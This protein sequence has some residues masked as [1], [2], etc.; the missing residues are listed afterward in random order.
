M[1]LKRIKTEGLKKEDP[2]IIPE[3]QRRDFLKIGLLIT[4]IFAGGGE[5]F[6][7]RQP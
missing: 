3:M 7:G 5:S 6:R 1:I 4:G 2:A